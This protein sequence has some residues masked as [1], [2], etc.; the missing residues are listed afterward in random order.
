MKISFDDY[1]ELI[2]DGSHTGM[3][4][5][6]ILFAM[7]QKKPYI[8]QLNKILRSFQQHTHQEF[9]DFFARVA[10]ELQNLP[11]RITITDDGVLRGRF[12][13]YSHIAYNL[14]STLIRIELIPTVIDGII[15]QTTANDVECVYLTWILG[16]HYTTEPTS[17][18]LKI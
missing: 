18:P 2:I 1:L 10:V 9:R 5:E 15:S 6:Y 12:A 7:L 17:T 16:K 4:I 14:P 13:D 11:A 8:P 3:G